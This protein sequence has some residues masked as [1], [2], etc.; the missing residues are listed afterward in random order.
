MSIFLS[1]LLDKLTKKNVHLMT[2]S[3]DHTKYSHAS[4]FKRYYHNGKENIKELG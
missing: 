2:K 1:S 3:E 4:C